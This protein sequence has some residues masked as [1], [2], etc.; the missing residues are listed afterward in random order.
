M[1]ATTFVM[2]AVL[3]APG[4]LLVGSE[5]LPVDD[6]GKLTA[7]GKAKA[8]TKIEASEP[9]EEVWTLHLWAKIDKGAEGP[10][11][12]EFHREHKGERLLAHRVEYDDYGGEPYTS[13]EVEISRSQ[14]FRIGDTIDLTLIQIV[15]GKDVA[16]AKGKVELAASSKPAPA[17]K[18]DAPGQDEVDPN[19][20]REIG[21][22]PDANAGGPPPV[23]AGKKGCAIG[24]PSPVWLLLGLVLVNRGRARRRA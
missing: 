7:D 13:R 6:S 24:E 12:L 14:G 19:E 8:L 15:G 2:V 17:A 16:K 21:S 10:L 9:G 11:Y 1:F 4:E 22:T 5:P 20:A 23:E 18:D 3:A